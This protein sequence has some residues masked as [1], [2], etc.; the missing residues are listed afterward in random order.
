MFPGDGWRIFGPFWLGSLAWAYLLVRGPGLQFDNVHARSKRNTDIIKTTYVTLLTGC[1]YCGG[2]FCHSE[3]V[4]FL[5][6]MMRLFFNIFPNGIEFGR[7]LPGCRSMKELT[8]SRKCWNRLVT[9]SLFTGCECPS[10]YFPELYSFFGTR[11]GNRWTTWSD[12][13]TLWTSFSTKLALISINFISSLTPK[14]SI[15]ATGRSINYGPR[16]ASVV[17]EKQIVQPPLPDEN[18][19]RPEWMGGL[20]VRPLARKNCA[21]RYH[22][23][24]SWAGGRRVVLNWLN[25]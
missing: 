9:V 13:P 7:L 6:K 1:F 24:L 16:C 22:L 19:I 5:W 11:R 8:S 21:E 15:T 17:A 18:G 23:S 2:H 20:F 14:P 10:I 25:R 3:K 12:L 4:F